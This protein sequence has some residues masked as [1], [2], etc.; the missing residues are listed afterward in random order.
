ME[1]HVRQFHLF[2][3]NQNR[4]N[5]AL[6]EIVKTCENTIDDRHAVLHCFAVSAGTEIPL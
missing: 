4:T 6:D 3:H 5:A 1:A 2:H